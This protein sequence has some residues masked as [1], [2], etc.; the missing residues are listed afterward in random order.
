MLERALL[1][2]WIL[3]VIVD[4]FVIILISR[5]QRVLDITIGTRLYGPLSVA[6]SIDQESA[7]AEH[8]ASHVALLVFVAILG[9]LMHH[10]L[11]CDK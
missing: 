11:L 6:T 5:M 3:N 1:S 9:S 8:L 2:P 10:L 7:T 4:H